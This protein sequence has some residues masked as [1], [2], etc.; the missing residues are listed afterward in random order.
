MTTIPAVL[1]RL[2]TIFGTALPDARIDDGPTASPFEADPD[3]TDFGVVV[4]WQDDGPGVQNDITREGGAAD[5][6]E[7]YQV[8][9]QISASSGDS[10]TLAL[11]ARVFDALKALQKQLRVEHPIS[12]GVL[13]A[14][15]HVVDYDPHH[16]TD[17]VEAVLTF[18]V[19]V[20]AFDR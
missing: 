15:I 1:E 20:D 6:R 13:S 3:G 8:N 17:G 12:P 10:N 7:T 9:C 2:V 14:W 4:G 5:N 19:L 18:A 11:R 16:I